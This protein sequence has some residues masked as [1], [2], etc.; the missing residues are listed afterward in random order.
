M[1]SLV[2][3]GL[4]KVALGLGAAGLAATAAGEHFKEKEI[5]SGAMGK[6][7]EEI[8]ARKTARHLKQIGM[9]SM[10]GGGVLGAKAAMPKDQ[11]K[12]EDKSMGFA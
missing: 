10:V 7:L 2:T 9:G 12:E 1:I 3:E 5:A 6:D 11:K 8:K 4:G